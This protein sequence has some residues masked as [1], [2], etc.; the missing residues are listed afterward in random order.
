MSA[1]ALHKQLH[2]KANSSDNIK[3]SHHQLFVKGSTSDCLSPTEKD[4]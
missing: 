2:V 4:Q 3:D 1:M